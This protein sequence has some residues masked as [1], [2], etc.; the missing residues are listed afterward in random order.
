MLESVREVVRV[1]K[2]TR[3]P[4][5]PAPVEGIFDLRGVLVPV[6]DLRK[7]LGLPAK[8]IEV[9][10]HLIV[11]EVGPQTVAI[12][13]DAADSLHEVEM[14]SWDD[15]GDPGRERELTAGIAR[16]PDGLVVIYDLERFLSV[17]EAEA[18][19]AALALARSAAG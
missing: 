14:H 4:D 2:L 17:P 7:R 8:E 6:L 12:R 11:A 9:S 13:V 19:L 10:D 3:L 16:L 1:V 5:A 18:L 15:V